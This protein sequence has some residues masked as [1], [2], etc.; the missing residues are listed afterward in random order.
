MEIKI[1]I[2]KCDYIITHFSHEF[3]F[4]CL[5]QKRGVEKRTHGK[6][7]GINCES[8]ISLKQL[9]TF[10]QISQLAITALQNLITFRS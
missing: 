7:S 8:F 6:I 5:L 4:G 10:Y 9:L 3:E 2:A 1:V